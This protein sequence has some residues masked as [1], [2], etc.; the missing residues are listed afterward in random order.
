MLVKS[1]VRLTPCPLLQ[2]EKPPRSFGSFEALLKIVFLL[3]H[4]LYDLVI[5]CE[6]V[7]IPTPTMSPRVWCWMVHMPNIIDNVRMILPFRG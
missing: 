7:L 5:L 1:T 4:A 6:Q 2:L 3:F